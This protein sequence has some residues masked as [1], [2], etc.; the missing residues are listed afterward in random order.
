MKYF[1]LVSLIFLSCFTSHNYN[2]IIIEKE[3]TINKI[4]KNVEKFL[5][6]YL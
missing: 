2:S 1:L 3:K 4:N 5:G 6:N